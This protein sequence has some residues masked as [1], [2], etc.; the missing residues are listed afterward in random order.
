MLSRSSL[1][2]SALVLAGVTLG[3]LAYAQTSG[4]PGISISYAQIGGGGAAGG[5]DGRAHLPTTPSWV[6]VDSGPTSCASGR[7]IT[8]SARARTG[9]VRQVDVMVNALGPGEIPLGGTG[10]PSAHIEATLEDGEVLQSD[11]GSVTVRSLTPGAPNVLDATFSWTP[12]LDGHPLLMRGIVV[13]PAPAAAAT[14]AH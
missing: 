9:H 5:L 10:C 4:R 11:D 12:R 14:P 1:R 13:V 2:A 7:K 6:T 8:V 3:G